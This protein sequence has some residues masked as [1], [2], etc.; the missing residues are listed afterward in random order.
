[1]PIEIVGDE[2]IVENVDMNFDVKFRADVLEL[3]VPNGLL[4]PG[5][6]YIFDVLAIE[7]SCNQTITEGFFTTAG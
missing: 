5:T 7:E 4:Q 6:E 2:V 1:M 3:T